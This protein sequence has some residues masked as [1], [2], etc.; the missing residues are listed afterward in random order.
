MNKIMTNK[1]KAKQIARISKK[2][3]KC[4]DDAADKD[5][6]CYF[7]TSEEECEDSALEMAE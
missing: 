5:R 4:Y 1:E 3:Y 6:V 7:T 2:H